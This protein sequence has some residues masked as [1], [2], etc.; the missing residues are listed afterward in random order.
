[1]PR[2]VAHYVIQGG[3][4]GK[5]R[6]SVL[7]RTLWPTT[8]RLLERAGIGPGMTCLDLGSGGGDVT[9][10]LAHLVG[11]SGRV[12]GIDM[13]ETKLALAREAAAEQGLGNVDFVAANV[14]TWSEESRYDLVYC[15]FLLTHLSDPLAILGRIWRA[16]RPGGRA[17]VED[18]E[19]SGS[20]CHPPSRAFDRSLDLYRAVVTRRGGDADIGPKL[21]RMALDAGWRDVDLAMVQPT[22]AHGEGK[23][24]AELTLHN[25]AASVLEEK[26]ASE[27]ELRA[28]E[29]ELIAFT[30]ADDTIVS[31]PRIFQ[32][33]ATRSAA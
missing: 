4:E 7:A 8:S 18:I 20:F 10:E 15:R 32:I 14:G 22:F 13:D 19:M 23:R 28:V 6:L 1:M 30:V 29:S 17:V 27:D 31:L 24:M 21:Y 33:W 11:P 3:I 25:I 5:K 26:L 12:T 16:V 2:L 9:L